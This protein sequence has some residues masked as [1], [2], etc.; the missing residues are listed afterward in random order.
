M[1]DFCDSF[2]EASNG[3][4]TDDLERIWEEAIMA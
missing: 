4:M 1:T 3:K 2:Y